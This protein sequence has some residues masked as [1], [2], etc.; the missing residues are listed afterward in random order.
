MHY[1]PRPVFKDTVSCELHLIGTTL[2]T[3]ATELD[4]EIVEFLRP[5][6]DFPSVEDL[7]EQMEQDIQQAKNILL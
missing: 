7:Q 3:P 4:V 6:R 1:G 2:A 5:I